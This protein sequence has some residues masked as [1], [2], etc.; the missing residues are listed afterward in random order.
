MFDRAID[1][2]QVTDGIGSRVPP[3]RQ[4]VDRLDPP[5]VRRFE[6]GCQSGNGAE[7]NQRKSLLGERHAEPPP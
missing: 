2:D 3:P 1:T 7:K 6:R 4:I 5:D